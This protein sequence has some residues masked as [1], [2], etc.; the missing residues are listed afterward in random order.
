M[1]F[2]VFFLAHRFFI[3]SLIGNGAGTLSEPD[4]MV[5]VTDRAF[6]F[7]TLSA[8]CKGE[9]HRHAASNKTFATLLV[10]ITESQL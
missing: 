3:V 4:E 8:T 1:L 10:H 5:S 7:R 6:A 9:R 2:D